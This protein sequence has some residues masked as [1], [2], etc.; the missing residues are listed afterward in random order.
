MTLP[1]SGNQDANPAPAPPNPDLEQKVASHQGQIKEAFNKAASGQ[2]KPEAPPEPKDQTVDTP[3][4]Y[5]KKKEA[6][7]AF[8]PTKLSPELQEV[9][10]SMQADFTKKWTEASDLRKQSEEMRAKLDEERRVMLDNQRALLDALKAG[11]PEV[12]PAG[13]E[14]PMAQIQAL[15]EEGQHAEADQL[16]ASYLNR[17]AE[18]RV[19]PIKKE[20]ELNVLKTTFRDTASEVTTSN[21]V[22]ARYKAEVSQIFDGDNPLMNTIRPYLFQSNESI[23]TFVPLVL[24][25]IATE[26]HAKTLEERYEKAVESKVN[27]ILE[28]RRA[29]AG[30]IPA[31][32]VES[33]SV[34]RSSAPGKLSLSE[35]FSLAKTGTEQ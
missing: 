21:P 23:R 17:L 25:A 19:A 8:D 7:P 4:F 35:S 22:V 26:I 27:E 5:T 14:D 31:R 3:L 33:G 15:R 30:R 18:E 13:T 20:A 2:A 1:A 9:Y 34:S 12:P 16:L 24:N 28:A 29:S 6:P 10:K 11:R 32:L